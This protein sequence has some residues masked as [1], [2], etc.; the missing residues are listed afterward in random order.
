M[1][2]IDYVLIDVD[3]IKPNPHNDLHSLAKADFI[4]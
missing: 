3:V 1:H 2:A 4:L